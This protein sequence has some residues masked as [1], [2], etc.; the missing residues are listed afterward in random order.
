V[1]FTSVNGVRC[2]LTALRAEGRDVRRLGNARIAAIGPETARAVES[3]GLRVDF[4]PAQYVAEQVAAEFPEPVAGKRVLIPRARE[5]RELLPETWRAQ[6][7]TVD[8]VPVYETVPDDYADLDVRE[9]LLTGGV[10]VVTFTASSTVK[11]FMERYGDL[12]LGGLTVACIGPITADTARAAGLRVDVVAAEH[13]VPGL[14]EAL[15]EHWAS[16]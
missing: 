11:G 1:V 15:E 9:Q 3:V 16:K 12:D 8:V 6:G 2:L 4:V 14:V 7:A 13:T 5:A 10:D